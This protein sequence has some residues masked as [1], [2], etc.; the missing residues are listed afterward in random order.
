MT[1]AGK[2]EKTDLHAKTKRII[3]SPDLSKLKRVQ[4]DSKTIRFL[5]P[6]KKKKRYG[7]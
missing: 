5:K 6:D 7:N 1:T 3:K 4:V 2:P